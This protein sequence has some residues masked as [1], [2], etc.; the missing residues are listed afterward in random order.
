[1]DPLINMLI[2]Q[3]DRNPNSLLAR[4][5]SSIGHH[6]YLATSLGG[7]FVGTVL[8]LS[9][10]RSRETVTNAVPI[11]P[12]LSVGLGVADKIFFDYIMPD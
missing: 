9:L 2:E 8:T 7:F 1:M 5:T 3:T 4:M 11:L 6:P 12:F 10:A